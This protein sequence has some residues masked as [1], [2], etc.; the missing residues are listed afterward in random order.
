[1]RP[2]GTPTELEHRRRLAVQRVLD[3]YSIREVAKF[4]G[5]DPSSVRRWVAAFRDQGASGLA[6]Q[7]VPGRPAKLTRTQEKILFRWL[8][9]SPTEHG[10]DTELWTGRRLAAMIEQEWDVRLNPRYLACWLS[11]RG[12]SPQMPE[13][14][15]SRRD[16]EEIALWLEFDWPRIKKKQEGKVP[17]SP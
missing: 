15:P 17:G 11:A 8:A 2:K 13:R 14:V 1:M 3:G 12:Y 16:P 4:L 7:P 9:D 6:A 5:V 10:F